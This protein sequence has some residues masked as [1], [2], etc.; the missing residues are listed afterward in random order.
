MLIS[1]CKYFITIDGNIRRH[2]QTGL[3][4]RK[5]QRYVP[6]GMKKQVLAFDKTISQTAANKVI[7]S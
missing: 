6:A 3:H 1:D 2:G 7:K 4:L 5:E